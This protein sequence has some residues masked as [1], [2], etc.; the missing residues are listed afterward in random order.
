MIINWTV[1]YMPKK[2]EK[3]KKLHQNMC[4]QKVKD[5][6]TNQADGSWKNDKSRMAEMMHSG[7]HFR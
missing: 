7:Y 4:R 2:Q 1:V 5:G 6:L 3:K